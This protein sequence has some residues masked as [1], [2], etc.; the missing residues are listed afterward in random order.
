MVSDVRQC[1]YS[2]CIVDELLYPSPSVHASLPWYSDMAGA[3][4]PVR[5]ALEQG[6]LEWTDKRLTR[7]EFQALKPSERLT[8]KCNTDMEQSVPILFLTPLYMSFGMLAFG[9][10]L[11]ES[12]AS[13]RSYSC[14]AVGFD[15]L[16]AR[17]DK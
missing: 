5:W 4:E 13:V 6:G 8:S 17:A 9:S 14:L 12:V 2:L 7:E 3:A 11:L 10:A 16:S 15:P 1:P